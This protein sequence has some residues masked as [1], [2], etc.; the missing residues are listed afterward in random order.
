MFSVCWF[1]WYKYSHH[2]QF[3][4]IDMMLNTRLGRD[5]RDG[6]L[7]ASAGWLQHTTACERPPRR[8]GCPSQACSYYLGSNHVLCIFLFARCRVEHDVVNGLYQFQLD[9]TLDE[10]AGK[11]FLIYIR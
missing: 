2:G 6:L 7:R 11:Q 4:A 8:Q 5:E 10:E 9:H 1:L 3:H